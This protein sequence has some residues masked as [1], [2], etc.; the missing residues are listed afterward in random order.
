MLRNK[1][2]VRKL[3]AKPSANP[4]WTAA[5]QH[6]PI[7]TSFLSHGYSSLT[8]IPVMRGLRRRG[9]ILAFAG[10]AHEAPDRMRSLH[11]LPSRAPWAYFR[12]SQ[13]HSKLLSTQAWHSLCVHGSQKCPKRPTEYRRD[14]CGA[15]PIRL[16]H[17]KHP[18]NGRSQP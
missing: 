12:L 13:T 4:N 9:V 3:A 17:K 8:P 1:K 10:C 2:L 7:P 16:G 6:R 5:G 11:A 18:T 15:R 14:H